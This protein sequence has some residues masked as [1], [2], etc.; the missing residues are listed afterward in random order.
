LI[1]ET[2][3]R[4][5]PEEAGVVLAESRLVAE[6]MTIFLATDLTEGEDAHG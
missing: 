1:E 5:K 3:H 6:K 2:G 4:A